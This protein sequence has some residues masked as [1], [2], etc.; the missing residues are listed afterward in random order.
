MDEFTLSNILIDHL[1]LF[2]AMEAK[3][4]GQFQGYMNRYNII[5]CEDKK[6][7]FMCIE[8]R[9]LIKQ[10]G[11]FVERF[12]ELMKILSDRYAKIRDLCLYHK[13]YS[14]HLVYQ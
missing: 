12:S 9:S 4:I 10:Q 8:K 7:I 11:K 6:R 5:D 13:N 3:I 14:Y 2:E 1:V